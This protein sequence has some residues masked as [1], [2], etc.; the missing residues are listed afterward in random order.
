LPSK[1]PVSK[2]H[3]DVYSL[4]SF[5]HLKKS[6]NKW[7]EQAV[8]GITAQQN[9]GHLLAARRHHSHRQIEHKHPAKTQDDRVEHAVTG[10]KMEEKH[11]QPILRVQ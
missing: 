11:Q 7:Y 9:K 1:H 8:E 4:L 2:P 5:F 10:H 3:D 6:Y